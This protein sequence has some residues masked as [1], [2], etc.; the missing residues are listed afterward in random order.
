[1][2]VKSFL[3]S[4]IIGGFFIPGIVYAYP[5]KVQKTG[6]VVTYLAGDDGDIQRGAVLIGDRFTDNGDGTVTDNLTELIWLRD[7]HCSS[8]ARDGLTDSLAAVKSLSSG[9]CE[10]TDGSVDGDWRIPNIKEFHSLINFGYH[11]P[12]L[13]NTAGTGQFQEGDP[14]KNLF[15]RYWTSSTAVQSPK[16]GWAIYVTSGAVTNSVY[17]NNSSTSVWPVRGGLRVLRVIPSGTGSGSVVSSN[18]PGIDCGDDCFETY[19]YKTEVVL[20]PEADEGSAFAGWSGSADCLDGTVTLDTAKRCT[21]TFDLPYTITTSATPPGR[22]SVV[23]TP[24][25]VM[26]GSTSACT[27]T[28]NTGY[29]IHTVNGTCGVTFDGNNY[30]TNEVTADCTVT[31]SFAFPGDVNGDNTV[32]LID[33]VLSLQES[34]GIVTHEILADYPLSGVDVN[35]DGKLGLAEAIYTLK[36]TVGQ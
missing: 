23:C 24:N 21:A 20:A 25:P 4:L 26:R 5:A 10:L 3:V 22:G 13:S 15:S 17:K 18:I 14:F 1:M 33:A 6:Q 7:A 31:A 30:V 35:G 11:D 27:I 32:D 34:A 9:T 36:I 12:A 29:V 8:I 2:N 19:S 16:K 28:P